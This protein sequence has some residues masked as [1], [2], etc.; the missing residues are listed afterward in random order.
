M[1]GLKCF[2][3]VLG[4]VLLATTSMV[5]ASD[6]EPP[7]KQPPTNP[8]TQGS[9]DGI[10]P[11]LEY[12]KRIQ[13]AQ[14]IA[15]LQ[16][17]LFGEQVSLYDGGTSFVVDD[18]DVPGNNAL[19]VRLSRRLDAQLQPQSFVAP[20]DTRLLGIGNWDI[21][22]PYLAATVPQ[23]TG[24]PTP[25]CTSRG[26]PTTGFPHFDLAEVWQGVNV[27]IPGRGNTLALSLPSAAPRPSDGA[28][29][30][31]PR[32]K[33]ASATPCSTSTTPRVT[34]PASGRTM[35]ARSP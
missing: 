21:E 10:H 1:R 13:T 34:R 31:R 22:V 24:W 16:H 7:N 17:G 28:T 4:G 3:W 2:A 5:S 18:I 33:T 6:E 15:P 8:E 27:H 29:C 20:Y 12:E 25:R 26:Q 9:T 23:S 30:W 11:Y 35:A 19:P 14:T 32:W